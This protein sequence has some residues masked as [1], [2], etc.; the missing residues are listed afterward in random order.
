MW[1]I[2]EEIAE[3]AI[4]LAHQF[5]T[6]SRVVREGWPLLSVDQSAILQIAVSYSEGKQPS[7]L[8]IEQADREEQGF[9]SDSANG[10]YTFIEEAT[11]LIAQSVI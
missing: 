1:R 10:C 8:E 6:F 11:M 2:A 9:L 5:D 4:P 3:P 7:E